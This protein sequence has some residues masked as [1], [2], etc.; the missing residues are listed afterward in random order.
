MEDQHVIQCYAQTND[1]N[2]DVRK[3]FY[4]RLSAVIENCPRRNIIMMGNFSAKTGRENRGYEKIMG[5]HRLGEM[6]DNGERF[7]NPCALNKVVIGGS[8]FQ[9][10]DIHT[11]QPDLSTETQIDNVCIDRKFRRSL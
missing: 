8:V 1:S 4:S 3:Q 11:A 2:E 7:A 5:S 10:K 9:H 6:N